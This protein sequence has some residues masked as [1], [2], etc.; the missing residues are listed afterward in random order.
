MSIDNEMAA[1][2]VHWL[3]RNGRNG[4]FCFHMDRLQRYFLDANGLKA[5]NRAITKILSWGVNKRLARICRE[6]NIYRDIINKGNL[7]SNS[8]P[9]EQQQQ[10]Q[11]RPQKRKNKNP[12]RQAPRT[13]CP[14]QAKGDTA[15]GEEG[16][17]EEG[18]EEDDEDEE[19]I[20]SAAGLLQISPK[21]INSG[22][23]LQRKAAENLRAKNTRAKKNEPAPETG[24]GLSR[25]IAVEVSGK[26]VP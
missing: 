2:N 13:K 9:K 21:K 11:R 6:L 4:A 19:G 8:L 7:A 5:V 12:S 24:G 25:L 3:S 26:R 15:Y 16:G 22:L 23:N 18:E 14:R 1:I 17:E 20:S 10:Q